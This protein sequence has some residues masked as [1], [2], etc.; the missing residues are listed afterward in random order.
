MKIH[1]NAGHGGKDP[2]ACGNG[3]QEKNIT[4]KVALM[5]GAYLE[6]EGF[7]VSYTRVVD[8][9]FS[10]IDI[11]K[12][13]NSD[14]ASLFISIHINASTSI[15]ANGIETLVYGLNGASGAIGNGIQEKLVEATGFTNR[16]VKARPDLVVLNSTK[17]DA[18]LIELGFISSK[19]DSF[20]LN[21]DSFLEKS[22]KAI[23]RGVC[24]YYKGAM[25]MDNEKVQVPQWQEDGLKNLVEKGVIG[26]ENYWNTKMTKE[27]TVGEVVG[28]LGRLVSK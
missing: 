24:I 10:P 2:G 14:G 15:S 1:I 27:I 3:L 12:K 17:M 16:G 25:E 26:D 7:E 11:A 13:A 19:S 5:L 22:A 8:E 23:C 9:Y 21:Q 4:L 6:K 28:L 18:V 20:M